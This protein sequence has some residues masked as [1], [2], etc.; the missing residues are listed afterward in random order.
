M[1]P[2]SLMLLTMLSLGATLACDDND[3]T[4]GVGGNVTYAASL[5]NAKEVPPT[6]SNGTG[7]FSGT[8]SSSN[9]L[10]YT[11]TFSGLTSNSNGAH[12]HGPATTTA[13][14]NVLV[15]FTAP[16]VG[17]TVTTALAL[18][19]TSGTTSGTLN[20]A[21]A[22]TATVSGDSLRKLLNAG[23]LY[24]NVHTANNGGGEIRGQIVRQ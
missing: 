6:T 18:G 21:S 17:A 1:L 24:V 20:L 15:D 13:N 23:Q 10:T 22:V 2:R 19:A 5:N 7:T 11:L 9:V 16:P 14:A 3:D 12:I 8:L 4:T